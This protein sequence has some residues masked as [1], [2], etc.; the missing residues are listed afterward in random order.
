MADSKLSIIPLGGATEIGKN[1]TVYRLGEQMLVVDCGLMFPNEELLGVDIVL[2]DISYLLERQEQVLGVVLTHG[3]EDHIG[4]LPYVLRKLPV[5]IWA[6]RLTLGLIRPKLHEH[7]L[8][9]DTD[10]HLVEDGERVQIG[11]FNV[12]FVHVCHSIP[13]AC[14]IVIRTEAG[15]LLHTSDF[16][17]DQTPVDGR[18]ADLQRL[19]AAGQ[20]GIL[21]LIIDSTNVDKPGH[22]ASERVV[23]DALDSVFRDA[24]GRVIVTTF[25]SNI[26]RV[27][28]VFDVSRDYERKVT[29]AG[30]SM[31]Q[32]VNIARELGYLTV[33]EDE[34]VRLDQV[35]DLPHE[36]LTIITTGSQGEPLS[37][38]SRM[39]MGDHRHI[40]IVPG[41]TVIMSSTPVPGNEDLVWR[42]INHLFKHGAYVVHTPTTPNIH[43]SGHAN[44]EELKLMLNLARPRYV[45]PVHGEYRHQELWGR[46][47]AEMGYLAIKLENGHVLELDEEEAVIADHVQAGAVFVDGSGQSGLEDV[48]LRD[49][50]HLSQDGIFFVVVTV[51]QTTAQVIAGPD[52][53]TRGAVLL[54]ELEGITEQARERVVEML[55]ELPS[56]GTADWGTVRTDLRRTLNKL[57]QERTGRRPMVVPV[58]MEI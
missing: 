34:L 1:M 28:Q 14:S 5:P 51:D 11:P 42:T 21:A 36:E 29:V 48:V 38:L 53:V 31:Q 56:D 3:H 7:G 15:N 20:E 23:S 50:F 26:S 58:I 54:G 25:A 10:W 52:V 4:A 47:A 13:D 49:R 57:L 22:V 6:T 32:N 45:V 12:E 24:E 35:N 8:W 44:R 40:Q 16:K 37:A 17:F 55:S 27:Q 41:D 18:L 9:A 19:A 30:R 39:A 46:M 2:P 43:V 33:D